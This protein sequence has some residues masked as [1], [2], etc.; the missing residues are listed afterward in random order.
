MGAMT[1]FRALR[2][3]GGPWGGIRNA[4]T[5]VYYSSRTKTSHN[6]LG[7]RANRFDSLEGVVV[8]MLGDL[9]WDL[10]LVK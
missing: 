6:R 7:T 2:T 5:T 1:A 9:A 8:V 3:C 4:A 10:E